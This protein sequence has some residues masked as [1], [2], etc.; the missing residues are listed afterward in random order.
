MDHTYAVDINNNNTE[1]AIEHLNLTLSRTSLEDERQPPS[2]A[3]VL[4]AI[5]DYLEGRTSPDNDVGRASQL[6]ARD[7]QI[8]NDVFNDVEPPTLAEEIEAYNQV[9]GDEW[10]SPKLLLGDR[11]PT[12]AQHYDVD[13]DVTSFE[14]CFTPPTSEPQ[15][16]DD[17]ESHDSI[18]PTPSVSPVH[19]RRERAHLTPEP[20]TE[21]EPLMLCV[22]V[23][24]RKFS[25]YQSDTV[26]YG[27]YTTP[28]L[29]GS[30]QI[31]LQYQILVDKAAHLIQHTRPFNM[32]SDQITFTFDRPE[33]TYI[34]DVHH[35]ISVYPKDYQEHRN[36]CIPDPITYKG[37][38]LASMTV[39]ISAARSIYT[40][41]FPKH[42]NRSRKNPDSGSSQTSLEAPPSK[43]KRSD[44]TSG[45]S[46]AARA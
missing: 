23:F 29:L 41:P 15:L 22:R 6:N 42:R 13:H 37:L 16:Y 8:L 38:A 7:S 39:R 44:P 21:N 10:H 27:T 34:N 25:E 5:N 12:P 35:H 40:I 9:H 3:D 43:R 31:R 1:D 14:S 45:R 4:Q 24:G 33:L 36:Y 17:I 46:S 11:H 18:S 30:L 2:S 19:R 20:D 28:Y 26:F 32:I